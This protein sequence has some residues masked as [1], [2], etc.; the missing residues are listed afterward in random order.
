MIDATFYH[1]CVDFASVQRIGPVKV[2][3]GPKFIWM[4]LIGGSDAH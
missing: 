4:I 1:V 3:I 2:L